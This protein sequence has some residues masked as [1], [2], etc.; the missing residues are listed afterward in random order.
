MDVCN[1]E[2]IFENGESITMNEFLVVECQPYSNESGVRKQGK[3]YTMIMYSSVNSTNQIN[4]FGDYTPLER[5]LMNS[6]I[7]KIKLY[8]NNG[9]VDC[10][11]PV[12][13]DEDS[14]NSCL[15]HTYINSK[16]ETVIV[17]DEF[18]T[19]NIFAD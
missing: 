2:I 9:T 15:Q 12:W 3:N 8:L 13:E 14:E 16:N 6:D 11:T 1:V 4:L 17:F 7:T 10:I 19:E 18:Y 5:L